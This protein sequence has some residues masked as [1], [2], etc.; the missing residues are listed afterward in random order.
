[1]V[2]R[3]LPAY[4]RVK[5]GGNVRS[6]LRL[7]GTGRNADS[8]GAVFRDHAD[9]YAVAGRDELAHLLAEV[10]A[11]CL[12]QKDE[13]MEVLYRR[14]LTV[15]EGF[16]EAWYGLGM[17]SLQRG[18]LEEAYDCLSEYTALAGDREQAEKVEVVLFFLERLAGGG[19][20]LSA[21]IQEELQE[22]FLAAF[23]DRDWMEEP[24]PVLDGLSPKEAV[25]TRGGKVKVLALM[26]EREWFR[27]AAVRMALENNL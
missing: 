25:R 17:L 12:A 7:V 11:A 18:N 19:E 1:M 24:L 23:S 4:S 15:D 26:R 22:Q 9:A 5:G 21:D 16:A 10:R 6:R 3:K 8:A 14:A 20:E 13:T 2:R 27:R